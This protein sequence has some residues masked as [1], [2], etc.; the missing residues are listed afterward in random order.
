MERDWAWISPPALIMNGV[1]EV[2]NDTP[3]ETVSVWLGVSSCLVAVL[4]LPYADRFF[5]D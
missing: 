2:G 5:V 1:K 4:L 3:S